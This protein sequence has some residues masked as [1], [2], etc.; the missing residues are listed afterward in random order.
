MVSQ[1]N[2]SSQLILKAIAADMEHFAGR[3]VQDDRTPGSR[4]NISRCRPGFPRVGI[5]L[6]CR[7]LDDLD[8]RLATLSLAIWARNLLSFA[9]LT[10]IC[11]RQYQAPSQR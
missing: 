6:V 10:C 7:S 4:M 3:I 11:H 2:F 9:Y 8:P 5:P 1:S